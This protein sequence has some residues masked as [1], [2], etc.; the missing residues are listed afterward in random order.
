MSQSSRHW[1]WKRQRENAFFSFH[2]LVA[3]LRANWIGSI[4]APCCIDAQRALSVCLPA[5]ALASLIF[6]TFNIF[7]FAPVNEP[8]EAKEL[9]PCYGYC[10]YTAGERFGRPLKRDT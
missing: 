4:T 6:Q 10:R 9:L 2:Y 5:T 1:N 8:R 7:S 3:I